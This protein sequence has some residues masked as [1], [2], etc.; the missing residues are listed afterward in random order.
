[1]TNI[2]NWKRFDIREIKPGAEYVF[3][4]PNFSMIDKHYYFGRVVDWGWATDLEFDVLD[5]QDRYKNLAGTGFE[6]SHY[7]EI[8]P[9]E[10]E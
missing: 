7:F 8:T 1:M 10:A 2:V 6:P 5:C 4:F 3:Y 9:P